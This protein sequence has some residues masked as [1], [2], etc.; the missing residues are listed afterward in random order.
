MYNS[1][2]IRPYEC[3]ICKGS[4]LSNARLFKCS[5]E[6]CDKTAKTK[7]TI[8]THYA[9][10]HDNKTLKI[11][12][13]EKCQ[14]ICQTENSL[15]AHK[16]KEHPTKIA[17]FQCY[18]CNKKCKSRDHIKSHSLENNTCKICNKTLKTRYKLNSHMHSEQKGGHKSKK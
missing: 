12:E 9:E 5:F 17:A 16:S 6:G 14:K 8:A 4:C 7:L 11:F 15:N 3:E 2:N 13:C 10:V 18:L 1:S